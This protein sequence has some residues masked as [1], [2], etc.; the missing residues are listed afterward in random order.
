MLSLY[1]DLTPYILSILLGVIGYAI[2]FHWKLTSASN[3]F[4][5]YS[6]KPEIVE[7]C[8]SANEE[9]NLEQIPYKI[10]DKF[11]DSE[12]IRRSQD[13]YLLMNARR[14]VRHFSNKDVPLEVIK[15]LV[16][17]AG[18]S[19]SGAHT[20][21]WTF[22][23]V[24]NRDVKKCIRKIVEFEEEI[25]YKQRMGEKW[26]ND[27]AKFRTNWVKPYLECAPYLIL[28]FK[29][30]YSVDESGNRKEHYYNEIS[31]SI[32]CGILLA[33]IQVRSLIDR[34]LY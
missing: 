14:S 22:V 32:A 23:L 28:I 2:F 10:F 21:P 18:T 15:N 31:V 17:T 12:M 5:F 24:K 33:A 19:P 4:L 30:I 8:R 9:N 16:R 3:S 6:S 7:K 1:T 27:L 25:N 29:Q 13:F 26:C 34:L 20:Q 11:S